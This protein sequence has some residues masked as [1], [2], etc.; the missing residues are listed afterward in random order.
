MGEREP[1][2]YPILLMGYTRGLDGVPAA[3][4]DCRKSEGTSGADENAEEL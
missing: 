4:T 1:K 3:V 2:Y